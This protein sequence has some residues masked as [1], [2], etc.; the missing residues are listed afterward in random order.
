MIDIPT[1]GIFVSTLPLP[2]GM[3]VSGCRRVV[4]KHP[5]LQPEWIARQ[6]DGDVSMNGH[7][8]GM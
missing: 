3:A 4:R 7:M 5:S 6:M 2:V 8:M 1:I